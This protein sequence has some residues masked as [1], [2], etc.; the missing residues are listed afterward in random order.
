M[1]NTRSGVYVNICIFVYIAMY[2]T[3]SGEYV[4]ICIFVYIAVYNTRSGVYVN[5]C[6][7]V[8]IA[9][10]PVSRMLNKVG[11]HVPPPPTSPDNSSA[12]H[13]LASTS[14]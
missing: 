6:I 4:N 12:M 1:Y 14:P 9:V 7:F 2:N 3:R 5:I 11:Q 13:P 10:C 8:Y